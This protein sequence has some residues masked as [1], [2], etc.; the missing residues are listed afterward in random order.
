MLHLILCY[1]LEQS[2]DFPKICMSGGCG[3]ER[4]KR[5][6]REIPLG[7]EVVKFTLKN[8]QNSACISSSNGD[9]EGGVTS[10]INFC[11]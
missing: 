3:K 6:K 11:C 4:R 5:R 7:K 1:G 10:F 2:V 9:L 8:P